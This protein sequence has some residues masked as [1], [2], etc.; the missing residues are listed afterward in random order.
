MP[1]EKFRLK[2]AAGRVAIKVENYES[3]AGL[4]L[5]GDSHNPKPTVGTV[6]EVCDEY[7]VGDDPDEDPY[8]ALYK[9][10]DVV[11]FGKFTGTKIQVGRDTYILLRESEIL[12]RLIPDEQGVEAR[13]V[14]IAPGVADD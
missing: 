10:G 9:V 7:T 12:A 6:S 1:D 11:I 5:V 8:E 13:D 3:K 2:P 14:R 4:V